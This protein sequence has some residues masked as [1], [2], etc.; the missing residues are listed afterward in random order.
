MKINIT[1]LSL[2]LL[3]LASCATVH[4]NGYYQTK[5]YNTKSIKWT[6]ASKKKKP[7]SSDVQANAN[8]NIVIE[9]KDILLNKMDTQKVASMDP[10]IHLFKKD[11]SFKLSNTSTASVDKL[12]KLKKIVQ[13]LEEDIAFAKADI[14]DEPQVQLEEKVYNIPSV[15]AFGL[16]FLGLLTNFV[17]GF[18]LVPGLA[19]LLLI[20]G[21]AAIVLAFIGWKQY[22]Q[23]RDIYRGKFFI[24][25]A[26]VYAWIEIILVIL[27]IAL[28]ALALSTL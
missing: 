17:G 14:Q 1:L 12:P 27:L 9:K 21:I 8:D 13:R 5:R 18:T 23:D 26:Y 4:K 22:K 2:S 10:R 28:V 16:M 11:K 15:V 19:A 24:Y 7:T 6:Q 3:I 25:F 20:T